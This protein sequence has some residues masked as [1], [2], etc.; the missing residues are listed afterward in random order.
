MMHY[1]GASE[2]DCTTYVYMH[3]LEVEKHTYLFSVTYFDGILLDLINEYATKQMK[4]CMYAHR[5]M[6]TTKL[7]YCSA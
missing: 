6:L 7:Q 2:Y 3:M 1:L 4:S 5:G